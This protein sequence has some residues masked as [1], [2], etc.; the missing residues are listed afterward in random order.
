MPHGLMSS[1]APGQ[2]VAICPLPCSEPRSGSPM[3]PFTQK[4]TLAGVRG[5]SSITSGLWAKVFLPGVSLQIWE[6]RRDLSFQLQRETMLYEGSNEEG[7]R[8]AVSRAHSQ[9]GL[10][11]QGSL[12]SAKAQGMAL[13]A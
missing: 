10:L 9:G 7:G 5:C 13:A 8:G 1:P 6:R 3:H 2:P 4:I 12:P 11:R